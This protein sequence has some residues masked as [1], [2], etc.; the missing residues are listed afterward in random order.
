MVITKAISW[1]LL[2][3]AMLG[4]ANVWQD[5]GNIPVEIWIPVM[6]IGLL[7]LFVMPAY[8][9]AELL[10]HYETMSVYVELVLAY[11][12]GMAVMLYMPT[13]LQ[14]LS[15]TGIDL[16]DVILDDVAPTALNIIFFT[17]AVGG[18][19]AGIAFLIRQATGRR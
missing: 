6:L 4:L 17:L 5:N 14:A 1:V 11:F 19:L 16:M 18:P 12:I 8:A 13:V 9:L 10:P 7:F 2:G 15:P 3:L